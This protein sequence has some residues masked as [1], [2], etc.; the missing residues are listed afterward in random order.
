MKT[1][2]FAGGFGT[3]LS[4][5]TIVKPKPMVEIGG[6]PILWHIMKLYSHFGYD[7]FVVALGYRADMIKRYF[8]DYSSLNG[9]L[10][11]KLTR[12]QPE[13]KHFE[14]DAWT[15]HLKDTGYHSNTGG[16]LKLLKEEISDEPFMLT[17]GDGVSNVNIPDLVRFHK[18]H[19]KMVT[20]TAVRPPARFGGL[21]IDPD[22]C[23]ENFAEK[24]QMD[25]GWISG[26]FMVCEPELLDYIGDAKT[27]LEVDVLE[28]LARMDQ[29]MAYKHEG[30]WQCMDTVRDMNYLEDLWI[31]GTAPWKLWDS[32]ISHKQMP[33]FVKSTI[34]YENTSH[35]V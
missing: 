9:D 23:I 27:S 21:N 15:I 30:F 4:E 3:R 18:K 25:A 33:S 19:G 1:V 14:H 35:I 6:R 8:L 34:S 7:E 29:L 17:Y 10:T 22:G 11:V 5:E 28:K 20:I 2:I 12:H 32:S 24:S 26:G 13:V 31:S 16:R